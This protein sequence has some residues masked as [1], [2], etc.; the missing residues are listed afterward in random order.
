MKSKDFQNT[1]CEHGSPDDTPI[2]SVPIPGLNS[3]YVNHNV[4][5][6]N[7][8]MRFS[9]SV[10][11][12]RPRMIRLITH[13][14]DLRG[15]FG[16]QIQKLIKLIDLQLQNMQKKFPNEQVVSPTKSTNIL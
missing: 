10:S 6:E 11:F 14:D 15:L 9:R 7:G 4:A 8:E 2:F 1:K 12:L 13:R 3:N 16:N 5:I